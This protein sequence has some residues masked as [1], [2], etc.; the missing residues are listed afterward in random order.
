MRDIYRDLLD[1]L[2][3]ARKDQGLGQAPVAQRLNVSQSALCNW[4]GGNRFPSLP[5]AQRWAEVLGGQL[6]FSPSTHDTL[7]AGALQELARRHKGEFAAL[8]TA[9]QYRVHG[10]DLAAPNGEGA[11]G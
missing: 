7:R 10:E 11:E 1:Q 9:E 8:L 4:E 6:V 3:R 2:A 5:M